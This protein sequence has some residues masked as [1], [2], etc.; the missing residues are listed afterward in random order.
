MGTLLYLFPQVNSFSNLQ[1]GTSRGISDGTSAAETGLRQKQCLC[2]PF[3][4]G[5]KKLK[6]GGQESSPSE[7]AHL[8]V[9]IISSHGSLMVQEVSLKVDSKIN[10]VN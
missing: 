9:I 3:E 5:E 4:F 1:P 2:T 7:R 10:R 6:S 8:R